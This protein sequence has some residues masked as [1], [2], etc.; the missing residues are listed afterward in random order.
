[1]VELLSKIKAAYLNNPSLRTASYF[2]EELNS[3]DEFTPIS[4]LPGEKRYK[5]SIKGNPSLGAIKTIMIGVKNPSTQVGDVLCGEVWFNELRIA[6]IDSQGGWAAIGALEA[7]VADFANLS[8]SGRFSTVGFGSIDQSPNQRSREE[9]MQYDVVSTVNAGQLLPQKWGINLPVSYS[10]GETQITPE[11][12]PFYQDLRLE[13]RLAA[14]NNAQERK[15]I[16][17]QAI[18]YTKRKNIS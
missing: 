2:D 8:A 18:D 12:D 17:R 1:M 6:G 4:S 7:N 16:K 14:T 15:A 10:V 3:I 11:Y 9:L 5:L 13:D